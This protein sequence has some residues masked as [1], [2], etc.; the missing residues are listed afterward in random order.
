MPSSTNLVVRKF[1]LMR[2]VRLYYKN[3]H[4]CGGRIVAN[5]DD[6]DDDDDE[7]ENVDGA[8]VGYDIIST[9]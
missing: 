1:Y 9:T 7:F 2:I 4:I 6:D 8:F 5:D 3:T